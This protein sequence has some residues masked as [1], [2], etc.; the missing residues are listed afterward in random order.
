VNLTD[1]ITLRNQGSFDRSFDNFQSNKLANLS[2][3]FS[4]ARPSL[5]TTPNFTALFNAAVENDYTSHMWDKD[6]T[7]VIYLYNLTSSVQYKITVDQT[8]LIFVL[9]FF[10]TFISCFSV[11]L[12]AFLV[13]WYVKRKMEIRALIR[14]RKPNLIRGSV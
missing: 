10:A 4:F 13:G 2:N 7:L 1:R 6:V 3:V 8:D 11:L 5:R 14:V 12:V 9:Y